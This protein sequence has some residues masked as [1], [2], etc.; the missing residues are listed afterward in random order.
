MAKLISGYKHIG[1]QED[2]CG[3]RPTIIGHR[4]EPRH[5]KGLTLD[6]AWEIWQYLTMEQIQEAIKFAEEEK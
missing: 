4:I 1:I 5:M 2:V 3:S 6:E